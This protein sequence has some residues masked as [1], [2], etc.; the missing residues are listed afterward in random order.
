M[1]G[2]KP[3][4]TVTLAITVPIA[5]S[6]LLDGGSIQMTVSQDGG[7]FFNLS[8]PDIIMTASL[9]GT[10]FLVVEKAELEG[11][12]ISDGSQ[13]RFSAVITDIYGYS[14]IGS[15]SADIIGVDRVAPTINTT[16]SSIATTYVVGSNTNSIFI[17][18]PDQLK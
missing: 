5:N 18:D 13:I 9:G 10:Q 2:F 8:T 11:F 7:P 14:T 12:G 6:P 4:K 1:H 17:F 16:N 3:I 15:P